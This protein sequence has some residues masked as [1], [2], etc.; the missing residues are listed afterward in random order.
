MKKVSF[1]VTFEIDIHGE[2]PD[3][4]TQRRLLA[5]MLCKNSDG[6]INRDEFAIVIESVEWSKVM[7]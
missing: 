2:K 5:E 7:V 3:E 4:A 1:V 6:V